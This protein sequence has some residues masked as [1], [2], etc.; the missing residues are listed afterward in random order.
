MVKG[1]GTVIISAQ[2]NGALDILPS[3]GHVRVSPLNPVG[4]GTR[5]ESRRHPL[6]S[7]GAC[8]SDRSQAGLTLTAL[9]RRVLASQKPNDQIVLGMIGVGGMGTNRLREFLEK[10]PM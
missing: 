7:L 5:N 9:N 6:Q 10:E 8:S 1:L 3:L 2:R 4:A